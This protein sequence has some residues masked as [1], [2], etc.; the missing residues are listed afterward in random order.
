MV[1]IFHH[2]IDRSKGTRLVENSSESITVPQYDFPGL[3][4]AM[5]EEGCHNSQLP[6]GG[7]VSIQ[8][9]YALTD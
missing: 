1:A 8:V 9:G 7:W 3:R 6:M 4:A 5:L 2:G